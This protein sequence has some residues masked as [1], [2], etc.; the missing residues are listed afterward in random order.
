[1]FLNHNFFLKLKNKKKLI[2]KQYIL[3]ITKLQ[4][5][6]RSK[7]INQ[8]N[9]LTTSPILHFFGPNYYHNFPLVLQLMKKIGATMICYCPPNKRLF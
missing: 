9:H 6:T 1:M 4:C 2:L 5:Q 8:E 3:Y 7:K